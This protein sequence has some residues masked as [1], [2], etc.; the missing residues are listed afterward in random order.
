MSKLYLNDKFCS[1]CNKRFYSTDKR[2]INVVSNLDLIE[3]LNK[4]L[5]NINAVKNGDLVCNKGWG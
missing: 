2:T 4:S 3:K 5:G 1:A